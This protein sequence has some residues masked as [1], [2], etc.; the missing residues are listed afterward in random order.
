MEA[1]NLITETGE[2]LA[3]F[4]EQIREVLPKGILID[5]KD[6][7]SFVVQNRGSDRLYVNYDG[8]SLEKAAFGWNETELAFIYRYFP[9]EL[10]VYSIHYRSL[11]TIKAVLV[12]I[13]DSDRMLVDN[14]FGTILL[15]QDFVHKIL[16]EPNWYW[17]DDLN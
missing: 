16:A 1:I 15:G 17:F 5:Q 11:A 4:K 10:H 8:T 13:A 9:S 7:S 12:R 3:I 6:L 2:L 14:D